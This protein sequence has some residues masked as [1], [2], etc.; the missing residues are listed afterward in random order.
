[1]KRLN[2]AGE[3]WRESDIGWRRAGRKVSGL[4]RRFALPCVV[5]S[6]LLLF[7]QATFAWDCSA[8]RKELPSLILRDVR[9]DVR[10]ENFA[11][12][13]MSSGYSIRFIRIDNAIAQLSETEVPF[14]FQAE[15]CTV[16]ELLSAL[17]E[18]YS[19]AWKQD[20]ESG[21]LWVYPKEFDLGLLDEMTV[22]FEEPK[23]AI[24]MRSGL[25]DPH[26]D[27]KQFDHA[28]S[29]L[30]PSGIMRGQFPIYRFAEYVVDV[31][32]GRHSLRTILNLACVASPSQAF[33][34]DFF[35]PI[36]R[37]ESEKMTRQDIIISTDS[38]ERPSSLPAAL[39]AYA[40]RYLG[41]TPGETLEKRSLS[42][43]LS[44][45][46]PD[47]RRAAQHYV[48]LTEQVG[49]ETEYVADD[50]LSLEE[51]LWYA[52]A[53]DRYDKM[54]H[55][56]FPR[57]S[58]YIGGHVS[59]H[60]LR[61]APDS[62]LVLLLAIERARIERDDVWL[63]WLSARKF[64]PDE[65]RGLEH[66]VLYI[67]RRSEMVWKALRDSENPTF[68]D[69]GGWADSFMAKEYPQPFVGPF[70]RPHA[71]ELATEVPKAE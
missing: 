29:R 52:L 11:W 3:D 22:S 4:L 35:P 18:H 45:P 2:S 50:T 69:T 6:A 39:E 53:Y 38:I 47:V 56:G 36:R 20:A 12:G 54:S 55:E 5:A 60:F 70:N 28:Y 24:P 26:F 23:V 25:L 15:Q 59:E 64:S 67:A 21:V 68:I 65:L 51:N 1:M 61:N 71:K 63:K 9:I 31:P 58:L 49:F 40:T 7:S 8:W 30:G 10:N 16:A 66:E 13:L 33:V 44:S 62:H 41:A 27:G 42:R 37:A 14:A 48:E 43:H 32:D 34:L 17:S 19:R 57:V 46:D